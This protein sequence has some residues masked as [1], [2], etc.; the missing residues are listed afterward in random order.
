LLRLKG[1]RNSR[2]QPESSLC[3]ATTDSNRVFSYNG[4]ATT[5]ASAG[6]FFFRP[7]VAD[8]A[9]F[10][11]TDVYGTGNTGETNYLSQTDLEIM[12]TLGWQRAPVDQDFF[13]Q[14]ISQ[15]FWQNTSSGDVGEWITN[16]TGQISAAPAL[17]NASGYTILGAGDFTGN[18]TSDIFWELGNGEVGEWQMTNGQITNAPLLGTTTLNIVA[19]GDFT[20]NN[21]DDVFWQN[22]SNGAIGEWLLNSSGAIQAAPSLGNAPGYQIIGAGDFT[23]NGIDDILWQN[24]NTVGE[25]LLNS[26]GQ[27]SAAPSLG[28]TSS[29]IL[30]IGDFT[31]NGT[32]DVV[33]RS[34]NTV[35]EWIM[36]NGQISQVI[37]LGAVSST[38]QFIGV[39]NYTGNG[40]D[41]MI[42]RD[43][44]T[45]SLTE[46][47]MVGGQIN[48]APGL[49]SATANFDIIARK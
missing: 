45:G 40:I 7:S 23:G 30:G 43:T 8:A 39:G 6:L 26:S 31:G 29:Q 3:P 24:G 44:S 17:G 10:R 28:T 13:G 11:E 48:A 41:D 16:T 5:S 36:S 42:W 15:M 20:G 27:I 14:G 38:W 19:F 35:G 47:Q 34:G 12:Q 9:D 25:W 2:Q 37:T 33:W 32:D 4:G 22:G 21:I 49:G 1:S 18:G 46:W